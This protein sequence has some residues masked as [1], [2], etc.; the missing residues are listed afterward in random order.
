[1][2]FNLPNLLSL[3]RMGLVP[4][5]IIALLR[6]E[7]LRALLI[8]VA[9]GISD[10][11]D[12]FLARVLDQRSLLGAYLDPIADKLLLTTAYI[13]LTVIEL[14]GGHVPI[15]VWVTV[16]VLAR[17]VLIVVVALALAL[18]LQAT[19]FPP[20]VLSKLNTLCQIA[21]VILVLLSGATQWA[22][23]AARFGLYLVAALTVA[24]G[25]DYIVRAS[26]R[27]GAGA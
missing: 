8:F 19:E 11:L 2:S 3:L 14:P 22:D 12:G 16:L 1:M 15:P 27:V 10:A 26:R 5:F 9:A 24:S 7:P 21:A 6:G 17:D 4:L 18:A 13:G 25:V 23:A 20:T